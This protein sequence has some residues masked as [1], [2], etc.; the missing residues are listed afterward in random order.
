LSKGYALAGL[1]YQSDKEAVVGT[2]ALTASFSGK[3]G[4]QHRVIAWGASWGGEV[5]LKLAERYPMF[6]QGMI[7]AAPGAA[8]KPREGNFNLRY[9]TAYAAAFGWPEESWGPLEDVR[10][11]LDP[12]IVTPVFQW[13][14]GENYGLS[15]FIR[16]AMHM[17]T[18]TW[19]DMEPSIVC[20]V[21]ARRV[22]RLLSS[23]QA[24]KGNAAAL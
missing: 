10:D 6:Y 9:D 5:A 11:D 18:P 24:W 12:S 2:V 13:A 17:P 14:T 3:V 16:L 15:E 23:A 21:T 22:G 7:A 20:R 1:F 19:W 4:M 8:G